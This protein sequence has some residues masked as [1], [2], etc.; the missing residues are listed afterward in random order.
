MKKNKRCSIT[1][2]CLDCGEPYNSKDELSRCP[3]C[4]GPG[5]I[6]LSN[7]ESNGWDLDNDEFLEDANDFSNLDSLVYDPN[8]YND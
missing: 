2:E 4:D 7:Y 5:E 8:I 6:S 1:L 3:L